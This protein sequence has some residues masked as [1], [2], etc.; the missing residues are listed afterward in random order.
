MP[1]KSVMQS[2]PP[3]GGPTSFQPLERKSD[4]TVPTCS[5]AGASA[6]LR[7]KELPTRSRSMTPLL[8]S[9]TGLQNLLDM[10]LYHLVEVNCGHAPVSP[11]CHGQCDVKKDM[12]ATNNLFW[13]T[14]LCSCLFLL[15]N[16]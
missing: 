6:V 15:I 2:L 1:A 13:G 5:K 4:C 9:S 12:K 16:V 14:R 8:S 11:C 10:T 3:T 7:E